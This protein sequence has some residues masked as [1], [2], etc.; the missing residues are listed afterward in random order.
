[1]LVIS[2]SGNSKNL[3][4]AVEKAKEMG[5]ESIGLLGKGGG[6]LKNLVDNDII[7]RSEKTSRIQEAHGLIIHILCKIIDDLM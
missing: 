5:I 4:S 2:T 7:I 1:M 6:N 3:I